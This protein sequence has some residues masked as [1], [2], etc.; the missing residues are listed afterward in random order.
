MLVG[1]HMDASFVC[2][3]CVVKVLS[4]VRVYVCVGKGW[5]G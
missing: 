2:L 1:K 4:G 5:L 3:Y